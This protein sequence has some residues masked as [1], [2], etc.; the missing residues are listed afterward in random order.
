MENI[1]EDELPTGRGR[2]PGPRRTAAPPWFLDSGEK[3]DVD[4]PLNSP[5]R[6]SRRKRLS[7]RT[8]QTSHTEQRRRTPRVWVA[9]AHPVRFLDSPLSMNRLDKG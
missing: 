8:S 5:R 3:L 7:R 2:D 6:F 9:A 1:L 4:P